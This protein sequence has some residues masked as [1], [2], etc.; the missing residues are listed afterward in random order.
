M[1]SAADFQVSPSAAAVERTDGITFGILTGGSRRF[2]MEGCLRRSFDVRWQDG[3]L[4]Y[5]CS[6]GLINHTSGSLQ[7]GGQL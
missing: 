2:H 6:K 4:T 5:P 7:V 1:R 3:Q